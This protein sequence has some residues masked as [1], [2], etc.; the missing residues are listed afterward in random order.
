V[1]RDVL[2]ATM[3]SVVDDDKN[4]RTRWIMLQMRMDGC[5]EVSCVAVIYWQGCET[6]LGSKS[7]CEDNGG[8]RTR[9]I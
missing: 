2:V 3:E 8:E 5:L 4:N 6:Q 9:K 1:G 7:G